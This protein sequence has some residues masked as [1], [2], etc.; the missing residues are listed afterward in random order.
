MGVTLTPMH[1]KLERTLIVL[2]NEAASAR[3]GT[4]TVS[5]IDIDMA[6]LLEDAADELERLRREVAE[7]KNVL[8][9]D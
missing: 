7:Y 6:E 2:R 5:G 9:R 1:S 8:S 4:L 3:A